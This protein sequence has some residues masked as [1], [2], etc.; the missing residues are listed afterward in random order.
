MKPLKVEDVCVAGYDSFADV[1][2]RMPRF[3]EQV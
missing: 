2:E 1:A 3:I